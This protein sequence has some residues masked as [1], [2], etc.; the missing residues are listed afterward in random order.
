MTT[1]DEYLNAAK[2]LPSLRTTGEQALVDKG[3][4][5]GMQDVK[6]ADHAAARHESIYGK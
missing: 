3:K 5:V 6:N 1:K 4:A 2:K